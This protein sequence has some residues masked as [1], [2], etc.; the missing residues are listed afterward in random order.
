MH[1]V[2]TTV[3]VYFLLRAA[4]AL[5]INTVTKGG[6]MSQI[7][8]GLLMLSLLFAH[9]AFAADDDITCNQA[10]RNA[11]DRCSEVASSS[12]QAL[13]KCTKARNACMTICK[14]RAAEIQ[15]VVIQDV[16]SDYFKTCKSGEVAR[17][18][19]LFSQ[20]TRPSL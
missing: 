4:R 12:S 16:Y 17:K 15:D 9:A 18:H 14:Q 3:L 6:R 8:T 7:K 20:R 1:E 2:L 13:L 5:L 10:L 11:Q 19:R